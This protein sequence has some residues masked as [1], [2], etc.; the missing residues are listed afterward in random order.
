MYFRVIKQVFAEMV[1]FVHYAVVHSNFE[2]LAF[3]VIWDMVNQV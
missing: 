3:I 2:E 1:T